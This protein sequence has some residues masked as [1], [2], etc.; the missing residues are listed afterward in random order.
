VNI[1]LNVPMPLLLHTLR[2]F[3]NTMH[4]QYRA[5]MY[6]AQSTGATLNGEEVDHSVD[7]VFDTLRPQHWLAKELLRAAEVIIVHAYHD[8]PLLYTSILL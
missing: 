5:T 6:S 2:C 3:L 4:L 8:I 1:G 7:Y